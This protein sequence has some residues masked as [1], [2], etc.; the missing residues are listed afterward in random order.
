[1]DQSWLKW[2]CT[3]FTGLLTYTG[4]NNDAR[5][6]F[7]SRSIYMCHCSYLLGNFL[8]SQL[9]GMDLIL[10]CAVQIIIGGNEKFA[11]VDEP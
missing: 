4:D 8:E 3:C 6:Y 2:R 10:F 5:E 11:I 7:V 9:E 1:M